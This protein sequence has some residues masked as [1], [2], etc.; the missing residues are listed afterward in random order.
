MTHATDAQLPPARL[1]QQFWNGWNE[2]HGEQKAQDESSEAR[3]LFV[4]RAIQAHVPPDGRLADLGCGAGWLSER[5]AKHV[6]GVTAVDLADEVIARARA[7][8]PHIRFLAGSAMLLPE[9]ADYDAV[10][11]DNTFAHV[12]DQPAFVERMAD[13]LKPGGYLVLT[14][15]NYTV[16]S[17]SSRVMAQGVG[18]VRKWVTPRTLRRMVAPRFRVVHLATIFPAGD[19]GFLRLLGG[20]KTRKAWNLLFG[21]RRWISLRERLGLGQTITLIARKR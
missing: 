15:Q 20:G 17:R 19:R 12:D 1:Q 10:V 11:C 3:A 2:E 21:E 13:L 6:A 4:E 14:T 8:A 16:Y 18:Q 9:D 5:L 7:R